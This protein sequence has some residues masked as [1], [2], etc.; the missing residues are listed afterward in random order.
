M[1]M[2]SLFYCKFIFI[3]TRV[4]PVYLLIYLRQVSTQ[5][6]AFPFRVYLAPEI[7]HSLSGQGFDAPV[8]IT[9]HQHCLASSRLRR[10]PVYQ[11]R[12]CEA[13][14]I[15]EPLRLLLLFVLIN[16]F[17]KQQQCVRVFKLRL[18]FLLG[19]EARRLFTK[20]P[21]IIKVIKVCK[22]G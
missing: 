5:S 15:S 22:I 8:I 14:L 19:S 18:F 1:R 10:W 7:S 17:Q 11:N 3:F 4:N 16:H 12:Y 21:I 20:R 6:T 13:S 2:K 9:R